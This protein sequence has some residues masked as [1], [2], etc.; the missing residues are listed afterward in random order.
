MVAGWLAAL[1]H[2][3][4]GTHRTSRVLSHKLVAKDRSFS[5]R[6]LQIGTTFTLVVLSLVLSTISSKEQR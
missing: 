3:Q 5:S 1:H 6:R 4:S 2:M